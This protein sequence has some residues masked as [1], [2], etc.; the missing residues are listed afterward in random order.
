MS[1][2][3]PERPRTRLTILPLDT[4]GVAELH[5]YIG[6]LQT[7]IARCQAMIA[8]KQDHRGAAEAFF[9]RPSGG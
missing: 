5:A 8:R 4:L 2:D 3:I 9:K 7:E 6:E 1:D